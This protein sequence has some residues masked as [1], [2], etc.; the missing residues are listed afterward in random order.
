MKTESKS[1]NKI[2]KGTLK[3]V[4]RYVGKYRF[5][6]VISV[7]FAALSAVL[8]LCIPIITGNAIDAAVGKGAVDFEMLRNALARF[9]LCLLFIV[10]SQWLMA[11]LNNRIAFGVVR[12]LRLAAFRKLQRLPISYI[13]STPRGDTVSRIISDADRF[14]EGLVLGFSQLITGLISILGTIA[15]MFTLNWI[16]TL[17]VVLLTPLSLICASFIAR[18]TYSMFSRQTEDN[19]ALTAVI[20]EAV[21]NQKL[22]RAY[23]YESEMGAKFR[24]SN[25]RLRASSM[26]AIFYS[27]LT[28]PVTRFVNSMV[29]AV[30]AGVGALLAIAD[31]TFTAGRL[32]GFLIY[33]NQYTK[34]FNEI[35]GVLTELQGAMAGAAR[36]FELLDGSDVVDDGERELSADTVKG[37]VRFEGVSFSYDKERQLIKDLSFTASPGKRIAIVGPTGCGKTTLINLLMRFYNTDSGCISIDGVPISEMPMETLRSLFGMV[38]QDTWIKNGTVRENIA[39]GR[40][41]ATDEEIVAAAKACHAHSF[42]KR[43]RYGYDTVIGDGD[44]SLSQGQRQLICICRLMLRPTPLL[45]LDEATS[46]IDT[47]TEMKISDAF[48]KLMKG[49]TCF[50]VA[51]RLQTIR[52]ADMILVMK[53]GDVVERG[54]HKELLAKNGFYAELYNSQYK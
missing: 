13:D 15:F 41:D 28:N 5:S 40:P 32:S 6:L 16:I 31:P 53:N 21:E 24:E 22:I 4:L 7:A 9:G 14:S 3:R 42:I 47:R 51:H 45:I 18:R 50:I 48:G 54:N 36:I 29:Y 39:M 25:E 11:V 1:R 34:P 52:S 19:G 27:S 10:P 20:D 43:L 12:D 37:E 46:S 38:L 35:S 33:A 23:G 26:K 2:K 49:R 17:V 30:T 8:S 44:G